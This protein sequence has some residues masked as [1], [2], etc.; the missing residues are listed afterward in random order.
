ERGITRRG[1]WEYGGGIRLAGRL[2]GRVIVRPAGRVGA[3]ADQRDRRDRGEDRQAEPAER[4]HAGQSIREGWSPHTS[5]GAGPAVEFLTVLQNR[6]VHLAQQRVGV[7]SV[8]GKQFVLGPGGIH[9]DSY[10]RFLSRGAGRAW[11]GHG[12]GLW[13]SRPAGRNPV[14]PTSL[15]GATRKWCSS[16]YP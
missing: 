7:V 6:P 11:D 8:V 16:H 2:D 1:G 14:G 15:P 13:G 12:C 10:P 9:D 4:R 3:A 5:R